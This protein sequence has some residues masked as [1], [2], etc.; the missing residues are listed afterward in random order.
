MFNSLPFVSTLYID[1]GIMSSIPSLIV[2][3]VIT[4]G[5]VAGVLW[6]KF[7]K[8]VKSN[9]NIDENAHK[10]FE[11]DIQMIEDVKAPDDTLADMQNNIDAI[12]K[13]DKQD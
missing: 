3:A 11:D 1:V 10:K 2:A 12:T 13:G 6:R 9:L 7:K 8:K 4:V 5:A